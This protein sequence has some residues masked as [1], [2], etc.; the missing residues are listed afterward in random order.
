MITKKDKEETFTIRIANSSDNLL[1]KDDK[2]QNECNFFIDK[3]DLRRN[4]NNEITIDKES[5]DLMRYIE[6]SVKN[7]KYKRVKIE[8][9]FHGTRDGQIIGNKLELLINQIVNV[10]NA[11]K[12]NKNI[13]SLY[14][15]N[16]ACYAADVIIIDKENLINMGEGFMDIKGLIIEEVNTLQKDNKNIQI[17]YA[18]N[19]SKKTSLYQLDLNKTKSLKNK[20]EIFNEL[21]KAI[22]ILKRYGPLYKVMWCLKSII[23]IKN[24]LDKDLNEVILFSSISEESNKLSQQPILTN[25]ETETWEKT[26]RKCKAILCA[27]D[28]EN[29]NCKLLSELRK[30]LKELTDDEI[31]HL[32]HKN[33]LLNYYHLKDGEFKKIEANTNIKDLF[34]RHEEEKRLKNEIFYGKKLK[35][36]YENEQEQIQIDNEMY[37]EKLNKEAMEFL[38][39]EVYKSKKPK[40]NDIEKN[41]NNKQNENSIV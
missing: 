23:N 21:M 34:D 15:V 17:L 38:Q 26:N 22:N 7:D 4:D 35:T 31:K 20:K 40:N 29:V 11:I 24:G 28:Q 1:L 33:F 9:V 6:E 41:I 39:P 5:R 30:E 14:I 25:E 37:K 36:I 32:Y 10:F 13:I 27:F 8:I 3:I 19:F 12:N 16:K 2:Q 18:E